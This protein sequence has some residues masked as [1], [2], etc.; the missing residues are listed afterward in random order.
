MPYKRKWWYMMN[1]RVL[2]TLEYDKII[3]KLTDKTVSKMGKEVSHKLTPY[4]KIDTIKEKQQ[5]TSEAVSMIF[6]RG[7][8]PLGGIKDIRSALK[9]LEIGGTLSILELM[10]IGEC[11]R[12]CKNVKTYSKATNKNDSI[13]N[14]R[15]ITLFEEIDPLGVLYK[16]IHRCIISEEEIADDAS[17]A[18]YT[19]RKETARTHD[20]IKQSLHKIIN[21]SSSKTMLQDALITIRN[22]RYCVPIKQEYRH[23][24]KG[25]IHDQS[26]SGSTLFIEPIAVVELNNKLKQ[27]ETNEKNEIQKILQKLSNFACEHVIVLK[28]NSNLLTQLDFTFAKAEL[29]IALNA[30]EPIYDGDNYI[31]IKKAR[32]P[33][34]ETSTVVPIDI[35]LGKSFKT[36]MI[37]GPNTGGKT[38]T[39]KTIGLLTLMGQSGLH[40]PAFDQSHL[41]VFDDVFADIGDEQS[42]EQSL[43][44]F[45]SH[46]VNIINILKEAT[47]QSLVLFDELGAGTDPTEGAALAMS[48]L[49]TLRSRGSMTAATTHYSELKVY[50][51][52]TDNVENACCEFDVQTLKPTYKLLIG[53]PGKSNAFAIS[54]RLGLPDSIIDDAKELL[55][56]KAVQ[57]EDLI[58]DLE[59]SKKTVIIEKEK[60][61]QYRKEAEI[62]KDKVSKQKEKLNNQRDKLLRNARDEA[63]TIVRQ[64]KDDAD[65][66]IK[67]MNKMMKHSATYDHKSLE[68]ER[69]KLRDKL[70]DLEQQMSYQPKP[71][72]KTKQ[73]AKIAVGDTIFV[74]TFNQKGTVLSPPNN[75]GELQVQ[76]GIM[77]TS[78]HLSNISAMKEEKSNL[79]KPK[80]V[81]NGKTSFSK[82]YA[83]S[84]EVD[85]RG[86]TVEEAIG[87]ID[88]YL[89]DAYLSHLPQI[90]V[91][92]GKGTGTLRAAIHTFLKKVKYVKS[93]RLGSFGEGDSGVTI[94]FFK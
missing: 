59:V 94:V 82:A 78:V 90:T 36:L 25:M 81:E 1:K 29:S 71:K 40:I 48:I 19:I 76:L 39:L 22:D 34:L 56:H 66:I 72:V 63:Y 15:L 50:A 7:S 89:D 65:Q 87:H 86:S 10:H 74:H 85:V 57:F 88:K 49:E 11:L 32:H 21:A 67:R 28:S 73:P 62:L 75:K 42:I 51:L 3:Q 12:V 26:A 54:K 92:H 17:Q 27:L 38:V 53:I 46:M 60:A 2:H 13:D 47:S 23:S 4:T 43:S 91:I 68:G 80:Q 6:K 93:Y 8:L 35:Q 31:H 79:S 33:L 20:K 44:T 83:I 84:P 77:K 37:T 61:E 9:R 14:T 52:S 18:L 30:T 24:F 70:T 58:T 5:E 64:A 69:S 45:S 16:E 41:T 55:E